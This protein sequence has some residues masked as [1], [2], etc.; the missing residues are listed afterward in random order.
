MHFHTLAKEE[1]IMKTGPYSKSLPN[2][3]LE[4]CLYCTRKNLPVRETCFGIAA[5]IRA[6]NFSVSITRVISCSP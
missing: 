5:Y 4:S 1:L 6:V 3:P 2:I